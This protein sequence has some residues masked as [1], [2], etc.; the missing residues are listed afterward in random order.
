MLLLKDTEAYSVKPEM[1]EKSIFHA[2]TISKKL[3]SLKQGMFF[4]VFWA[5]ILDQVNAVN[6]DLEGKKE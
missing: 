3:R 5:D 4:S 6:K 1:T 2:E